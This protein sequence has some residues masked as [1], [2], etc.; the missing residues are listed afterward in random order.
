[1]NLVTVRGGS[2]AMRGLTEKVAYW[3]IGELMPRY[4]TLDIDILLTKTFEEGAWA[5]VHGGETDREFFMEIDKRI[6][7][8]KNGKKKKCGRELIIETICHEMVHVMQTATGR[9]IDRVYPKKEGYRKLWKNL[10]T[11]RYVDYS[12]TPYSKLPWE[13]QA[14]RMQRELTKKYLLHEEKG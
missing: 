3:C 2:K 1:M 7:L 6:G 11:G 14:Y 10:R 12:K 4:R 13:R 9:M 8:F 5:W